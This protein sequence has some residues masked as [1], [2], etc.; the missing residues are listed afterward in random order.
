MRPRLRSRPQT[1]AQVAQQ[2]GS[3]IEQFRKQTGR[4]GLSMIAERKRGVAAHRKAEPTGECNGRR[5]ASP[6][7]GNLEKA[8]A[9]P[10]R[11]R[12]YVAAD[13]VRF[14]RYRTGSRDD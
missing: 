4:A 3:R 2:N 9:P 10:G 5:K 8:A 7:R 1:L 6:F 12:D 11:E 14:R 13:R